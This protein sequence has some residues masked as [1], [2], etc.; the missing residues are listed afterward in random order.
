M[1][2]EGGLPAFRFFVY[3]GGRVAWSDLLAALALMLVF[4]G[5]LP[6]VN[7]KGWRRMIFSVAAMSDRDLRIAGAVSMALGLA[8]LYWVRG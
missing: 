3:G 4:E 2:P 8:A 1:K 5:M 6:F 7:P